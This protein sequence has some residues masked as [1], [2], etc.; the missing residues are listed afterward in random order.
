MSLQNQKAGAGPAVSSKASGLTGCPG[1]AKAPPGLEGYFFFDFLAFFA[2]FAFFA[3]LAIASSFGF[4]WKET[5][6]EAC[7]VEGY[8]PRNSLNGDPNRFAGSC[9]ILSRRCHRVIHRCSMVFAHFGH[10]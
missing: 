7:A 5:L 10:A 2:F 4:Q 1:G 9:L 8:K 3:F 6:H